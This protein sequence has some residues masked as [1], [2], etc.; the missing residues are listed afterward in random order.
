MAKSMDKQR[1]CKLNKKAVEKDLEGFVGR[2]SEPR[3]YCE[4]CFRVSSDKANLCKAKKLV[5]G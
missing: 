1:F 4:K 5:K 3:F 2:V